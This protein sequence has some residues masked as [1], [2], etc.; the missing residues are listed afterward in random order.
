MELHRVIYDMKL[1]KALTTHLYKER[2]T[3]TALKKIINNRAS[4]H[5][6]IASLV[7]V[8]FDD[9]CVRTT[10]DVSF[11]PKSH[12]YINLFWT[13]IDHRGVICKTVLIYTGKTS[14]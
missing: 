8:S 1:F 3:V 7:V 14:V 5:L 11:A 10:L 4:L 9:S 6:V 2:N 13:K 12:R